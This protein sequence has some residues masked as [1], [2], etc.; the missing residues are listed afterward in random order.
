[1]NVSGALNTETS[2]EI[3]NS[4]VVDGILDEDNMI[5]NSD[6][7]LATQQSIKA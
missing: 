6:T 4:V 7:K 1:L 2:L 5:S 3:N